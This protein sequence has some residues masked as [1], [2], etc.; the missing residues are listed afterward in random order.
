MQTKICRKC[1]NSQAVVDLN[2]KGNRWFCK[3]KD[4]CRWQQRGKK[5]AVGEQSA[6]EQLVNKEEPPKKLP[7]QVISDRVLTKKGVVVTAA[8]NNT[9]V[10][11]EFLNSLLSYCNYKNYELVVIPYTYLKTQETTHI[12]DPDYD[13][14]YDPALS[15]YLCPNKLHFGS[16][17]IQADL[18]LR[19][20]TANPLTGLENLT[21][22]RHSIFGHPKITSKPLATPKGVEAIVMHTTGA[23]TQRN[24]RQQPTGKKAEF[25]HSFGAVILEQSGDR[26]IHR[27][28]N[29]NNDG[30][31]IDLGI[32]YNAD[33]STSR[34]KVAGLV[35]GDI[36]VG[37]TSKT[38]LSATDEMIEYFKPEHLVLHDLFDGCTIN[39]HEEH[40]P[41]AKFHRPWNTLNEEVN[42]NIAFL[43]TYAAK[44]EK[45]IVVASNHNDFLYRWLQRTDWRLLDAQTAILYLVLAQLTI[46]SKSTNT[47]AEFLKL[48]VA[49]NIKFLNLDE[50][51]K[52]ADIECG[53]H[54]H[55]GANG[56]R[57]STKTMARQAFKSVTSHIH[58]LS[59]DNGNTTAGTSTDLDLGYTKGFS[60]WQQGH[61]VI[62]DGGKRQQLL[63]HEGIWR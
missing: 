19:P 21:E 4:T 50:S 14:A 58:Y 11:H 6:V 31:F 29:A 25:H 24:Y 34:C 44:V 10:A 40:N 43:Q 16:F 59:I 30:S 33:G 46:T 27:S 41:F 47:I 48:K 15:S 57:G 62:Y 28:I 5:R 20:T 51:Y 39:H 56:A 53:N 42:A 26:T 2:Q 7:F 54:G 63:I 61:V 3:D 9:Q 52:I 32:N 55:A 45:V 22:G 1:R 13:V 37:S 38:V 60:N 8:Q 23:V 18:N 35:M 36:H 49:A 12:E 17:I